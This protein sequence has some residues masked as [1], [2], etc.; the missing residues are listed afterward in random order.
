MNKLQYFDY[1][2]YIKHY[3]DLSNFTLDDANSHFINNGIK[4]KR[5]FSDKLIDFDYTFYIKHNKDLINLKWFDA[6][7]HFINNGIKE[8][9]LFSDK[10]ID[11][12][13]NFYIKHNKLNHLNWFDAC[14]NFIN[15]GIKEKR[16]FSYKLID[17]DYNFYI[18]HNKLNHLNWFD[19]C[20]HFINNGIKE[21]IIFSDKLIDFDYTFYIKH[22]KLNY[23]NWFDACSHFINNGI[24]EKRIF[25]DKLIDFDYNFY[26]KYNEDLI[27]LNWFDACSH[28]I[29]NGI[30]EKRLFSENFKLNNCNIN[31]K[32]CKLMNY[33]FIHITK[34]GGT[35]IEEYAY[36]NGI[37]W[38]KYDMELYQLFNKEGFWHI[39]LEYYSNEIINKYKFLC[40]VRNPY[41]RI[42]S[43][44]NYLIHSKHIS[45]KNININDY[46]Y[47]ILTNLFL[48]DKLNKQFIES[49]NK[50]LRFHFIPQFL[51]VS[52]DENILNNIT[53][54]KFENFEDNFNKFLLENEIDIKF[55][56]HEQINNNKIFKFDDLSIKNLKLINKIYKKDFELFDYDIY[57]LIN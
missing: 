17:F 20:S 13:Y 2:F 32:I 55:N 29:N 43:E 31:E 34:T 36:N 52:R 26:I 54:L 39:P 3:S 56:I 37:N 53:I 40:V 11:F 49:N 27:N 15:N 16:L 14:S 51:Y 23:L 7:I 47:D 18:K 28:F 46:L 6:C 1:K 10:L 50:C 44:I 9:R 12:D 30:K 38:G 48:E 45:N 25:S 8:K 41:S 42:I 24:K 19:A 22:N 35:S 57:K 33:K 4:E 5:L 21:N